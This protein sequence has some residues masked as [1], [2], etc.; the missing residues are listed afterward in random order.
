MGMAMAQQMLNQPGGMLG[1]QATPPAAGGGP[2][3]AGG[4]PQAAP[5]PANG[6]IEL[7]TPAQVAQ[8]LSV[9]EPDVLAALESGDLKGRKI[10]TQW[11]IPKA[12]VDQFLHG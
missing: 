8:L 10:G 2:V 12:A 3:G 1:Q 11:R 7:M 4:A 6:G 9:S 5:A